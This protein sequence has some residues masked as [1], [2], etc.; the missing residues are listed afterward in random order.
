VGAEAGRLR[1]LAVLSALAAFGLDPDAGPQD[2]SPDSAP[3]AGARLASGVELGVVADDRPELGP[4]W[5]LRESW[6]D[7]R[8][9]RWTKGAAVLFLERGGDEGALLID[10]SCLHPSG[11]TAAEV[12]VNGTP[13]YR[14][15]TR[16]GRLRR[17]LDVGHVHGRR[18]TV[19]LA[20]ERPFVP[21]RSDAASA[22]ERLLGLF[23]HRVALL[24]GGRPP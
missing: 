14:F 2:V 19:R 23:V 24:P 20:V 18:L 10:V 16:N 22:D 8:R 15:T 11:L 7:G 17:V 13:V 12:R 6:P 1:A 4:G 9:G 21:R 5:W 3:P